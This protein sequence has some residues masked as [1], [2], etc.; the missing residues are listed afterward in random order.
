[1]L[2]ILPLLSHTSLP[3]LI[4]LSTFRNKLNATALNTRP[5]L[6]GSRVCRGKWMARSR[7]VCQPGSSTGDLVLRCR[8][9]RGVFIFQGLL[10]HQPQHNHS[11]SH[12]LLTCR[13]KGVQIIGGSPAL[14]GWSGAT[15]LHAPV[16]RTSSWFLSIYIP[17]EEDCF[18]S[19]ERPEEAGINGAFLCYTVVSR[20]VLFE[21]ILSYLRLN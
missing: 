12:W 13:A 9:G 6:R 11:I 2:I 15:A 3:Y 16:L 14:W 20:T 21:S 8:R 1:M 19:P 7:P 17:L 5:Q 10:F 18:K 4:S